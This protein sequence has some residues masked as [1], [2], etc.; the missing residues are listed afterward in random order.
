MLIDVVASASEVVVVVE[1]ADADLAALAKA[2]V[3]K[4]E[5][6]SLRLR[7]SEARLVK[8]V[9]EIE[10]SVVFTV[11]NSSFLFVT[12]ARLTVRR[13]IRLARV[14]ANG[15]ATQTNLPTPISVCVIALYVTS[16]V[17]CGVFVMEW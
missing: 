8:S 16:V 6:F 13:Q 14:S 15:T 10:R 9:E 3:I 2:S 11:N 7:R 12:P 4:S 5:N 17:R 1:D